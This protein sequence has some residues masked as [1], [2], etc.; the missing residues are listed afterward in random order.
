MENFEYFNPVKIVFGQGTISELQRLLP[1]DKKILMLYGGGSIK[2]NGVYDQVVKALEGFDF[3]EFGGIEPNPHYE[4]CMKAVEIVKK[5]NIE[6]LLSVGG[7]SV[8]DGT[9]FIAA[10][11]KWD[12]G[13][14]WEIPLKKLPLEDALPLGSVIT[15]PATG[16]EMNCGA[17]ISRVSTHEK[18]HFIDPHVFPQ[19]SIIDPATTFTLPEKQTIN[20]IVDTFVHVMEQYMTRDVNTP[21]QDQL[22]LGIIK[23]LIQEAP[24]VL[25][26]P[27]DYD[28]RANLFWC[29]TL[30]LNG[31][32]ACGAVQD[33]GTHMLGHELTAIYGLDH[34]RTLAAVM[35]SLW[36]WKKEAK[37]DKLVKYGSEVW[38]IDTS[39]K[40]AAAELAI[41]LTEEFFHSIKMPTKLA[42]YG[43]DAKE[44]AAEVMRRFEQQGALYGEDLDIDCNA[45]FEIIS[46]S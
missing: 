31:L 6:F 32:I 10:A 15:L 21:L 17:V 19:F 24:K 1:K 9:K 46:H 37:A 27:E 25:E 14:P 7:G 3:I 20:G 33:W 8:L 40:D 41:H 13:D 44:A 45:A 39:D 5:E 28:V 18:F 30:G 38:E 11:A 2:S 35:P 26:N 12:K 36:R 22:A 34:A 23:T 42:A 4:T 16:S 29:A 43:I